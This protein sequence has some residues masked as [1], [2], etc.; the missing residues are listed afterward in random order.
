M[1][2]VVN[3]FLGI[4]GSIAASILLKRYQALRVARLY[5]GVYAAEIIDGRSTRP[6]P[7]ASVTRFLP[8]R[9]WS[10]NPGVLDAYAYDSTPD[11]KR[12]HDSYIVPDLSRPG[13]ADRT[14][15]YRKPFEVSQ[16][17]M[18]MIDKNLLVTPSEPAYGRHVLRRLKGQ[19]FLD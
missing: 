6:M 7:E 2:I 15:V 13:H 11:G 16:Q 14:V 17:K 1:S 5:A 3:F 10:R 4:A 9:L 12:E 8:R 18:E 19:L